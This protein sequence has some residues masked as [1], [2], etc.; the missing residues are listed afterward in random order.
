MRQRIP[1]SGKDL[2][3]TNA[4]LEFHAWQRCQALELGFVIADLASTH[5]PFHLHKNRDAKGP[6]I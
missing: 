6:E 1:R 2:L 5:D 3:A 4:I